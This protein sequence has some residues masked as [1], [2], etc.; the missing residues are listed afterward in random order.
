MK[1]KDYNTISPETTTS[2]YSVVVN[3]GNPTYR[4]YAPSKSQIEK[5]IL[6]YVVERGLTTDI[7]TYFSNE[8]QAKEYYYNSQFNLKWYGTT[9][10]VNGKLTMDTVIE[11]HN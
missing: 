8:E 11:R 5:I 3:R 9:K 4:D 7:E 2:P 10:F 6:Y 1:R